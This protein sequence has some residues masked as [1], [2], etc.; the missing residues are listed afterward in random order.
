MTKRITGSQAWVQTMINQG[1]KYVFGIPS[2]K[3][4]RLFEDLE[5][6][7]DKRTPKL[8][9]TRHEQDAA[10]MAAG[11]G[12]LTGKPILLLHW[13]KLQMNYQQIFICLKMCPQC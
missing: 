10:F 11:I 9:I 5:H 1:I 3:I 8:I 13:T 7:D 6:N 2:A 4:D 12:R